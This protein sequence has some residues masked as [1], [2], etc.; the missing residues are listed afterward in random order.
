MCLSLYPRDY[1]F[2]FF[3][4]IIFYRKLA[5]S[6]P[7]PVSLHTNIKLFKYFIFIFIFTL[8]FVWCALSAETSSRWVGDDL[9]TVQYPF[10]GNFICRCLTRQS[11]HFFVGR[12][13]PLII[14][15]YNSFPRPD[16]LASCSNTNDF[17]IN[18]VGGF[19]PSRK[20]VS[21]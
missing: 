2:F 1:P 4:F 21:S 5:Q 15:S 11:L 12:S 9:G 8:F 16:M 14:L 17:Y 20:W 7:P 10:G 6:A 13:S 3:I 18:F 19:S